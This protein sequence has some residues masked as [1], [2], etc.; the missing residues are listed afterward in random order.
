MVRKKQDCPDSATCQCHVPALQEGLGSGGTGI[1]ERDKAFSHED[2]DLYPEEVIV[3]ISSSCG[4][5][6]DFEAYI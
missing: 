6:R 5:F 4:T 1:Y 3:Q 2:C